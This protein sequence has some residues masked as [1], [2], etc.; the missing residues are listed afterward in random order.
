MAY[1]IAITGGIGSGKSAV[2]RCLTAWGLRVYNCDSRAK[3]LMDQSPEIHR[4]LCAEIAPDVVKDGVIDRPRLAQLVF[5]DA[6]LL[7]KL[8]AIVHSN[9][10]S[11]IRRWQQR[12]ADEPLLFVET[13]ILLESNL[14]H[15]VNEV[16]LVDADDE[17][18]LQRACHRDCASPDSIRARMR[19]QRK[20]TAADL[21]ASVPL[22]V[23]TNDGPNAIIPRLQQLLQL[24]G[25]EA[26]Q[27][28]QWKN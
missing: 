8:N 2:C 11:D 18:R 3:R 15:A 16:W 1:L 20:V 25:L 27:Q 9:V 5:N 13:A 17:T 24:H 6:A 12:H 7:Q 21:P 14:H 28:R 26:S 19:R 22:H 10:A 23:I 4:R